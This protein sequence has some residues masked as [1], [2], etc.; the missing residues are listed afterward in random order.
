MKKAFVILFL[1]SATLGYSQEFPSQLWHD[2]TIVLI[3]GD[4]LK[5]Q[6]RYSQETD[7]V[8]FLDEPSNTA[9]AMTGQKVLYFE[10]FDRLARQYREFFALPFALNGDYEIPIFF[11]VIHEGRPM[12]L[13]SRERLEYQVVNSPYA[14]GASFSRL[15]LQYTYF[16]L[17]YKGEIKRFQGSRKELPYYFRDKMQPIKKYVKANKVRPERRADILGVVLYYNELHGSKTAKNNE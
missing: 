7:I 14:I 17:N 16:F 12:S 3:E 11:E 2:G 4:T 6:V 13:L 9:I 10:I 5:G 15:T 8:E 1:A